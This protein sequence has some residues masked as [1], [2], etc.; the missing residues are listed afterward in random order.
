V[1]PEAVHDVLA[2]VHTLSQQRASALALVE[3]G[4]FVAG[5]P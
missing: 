4:A 3:E 1:K 2:E 5:D